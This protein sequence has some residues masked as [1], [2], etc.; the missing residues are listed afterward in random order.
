MNTSLQP[1]R[2]NSLLAQALGGVVPGSKMLIVG[3]PE[4]GMAMLCAELLV[5]I[6]PALRQG[7]YWLDAAR[8][9]SAIF[10]LVDHIPFGF[11]R[12]DVVSQAKDLDP[13]TIWREVL[14]N[15][16]R[17][18][19]VVVVDSLERWAS[20]PAEQKALIEQLAM[21]PDTGFV[22]SYV[23]QRPQ[24]AQHV[25][26]FFDAVAIVNS[27]CIEVTQCRWTPGPRVVSRR[28]MTTEEVASRD[29]HKPQ[30]RKGG[31]G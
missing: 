5:K 25:E 28:P 4:M 7:A 22:L 3:R 14:S 17:R 27:D 20:G 12:L 10:G 19:A 23:D 31:T 29:E 2:I 30:Q 15:E 26:T 18:G 11:S 13:P 8:N 24:L 16:M 1:L 9:P 21:R 6:V